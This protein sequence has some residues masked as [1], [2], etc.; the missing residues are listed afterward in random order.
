MYFTIVSSSLTSSLFIKIIE[1][2]ANRSSVI[3]VAEHH[4]ATLRPLTEVSDQITGA[5]K[6]ARAQE[7]IAVRSEEL[8]GAQPHGGEAQASAA[9]EDPAEA[10]PASDPREGARRGSKWP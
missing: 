7:I 4:E 2:D 10:D 5:L 8:H 6:S 1:I 3:K 9:N